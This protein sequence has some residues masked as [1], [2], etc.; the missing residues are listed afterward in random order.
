M[1]IINR[2]CQL[3]LSDDATLLRAKPLMSEQ[4]NKNFNN[5]GAAAADMTE[6]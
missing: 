3:N 4:K 1:N 5:C 2:L 6:K